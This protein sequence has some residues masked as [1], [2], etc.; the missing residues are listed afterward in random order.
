MLRQ[1]W[2]FVRGMRDYLRDPLDMQE[3]RAEIVDDW[4]RRGER[5]VEK[6][7]ATVWPFPDSPYAQL[8]NSAGFK[9]G[10]VEG[11]IAS[12]G[13]DATLEL[14]RDE[15][16]YVAYEEYQ[17]K[18]AAVRGSST[19][20]F[21][22]DDFINP[23]TRA[24]FMGSSSGTRSSGVQVPISFSAFKKG[25]TQWYFHRVHWFPEGTPN[26]VWIP[27]LPANGIGAVLW[28]AGTG[29][30]PDAWF[31]QIEPP[32]QI[33]FRKRVANALVPFAA[34]TTGVRIP[35]PVFAPPTDPGRVLDWCLKAL[36][37]RGR[38]MVLG[39]A[40]SLTRLALAAIERGVSL[41]GVTFIMSG[42]PVTSAKA[43]VI[44]ES[45][46]ALCNFYGFTQGGIVATN[47]PYCNDEELHV[48]EQDLAVIQRRRKRSDGSDVDAFLYTG[49]SAVMGVV[50]INLESDDFGE[51]RH[52]E[53]PCSCEFGKLGFRTRIANVRGMSKV[54]A[55][56]VTVPGE[57][58]ERIVESTL[59]KR[60]GGGPG[61]YQ[62]SESGGSQ[63]KLV[64]RVD[65]RL[66][67]ID[68]SEVLEC[69]RAELRS[70][71]YGLLA[72][73]VWLGADALEVAREP[74]APAR[75]GK[76]LPFETLPP[77]P[78][79]SAEHKNATK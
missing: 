74:A 75:S 66:G 12:R 52:D 14:L 62:F 76:V 67:G 70:T 63:T 73:R 71:E 11:L 1:G 49:L 29:D 3:A 36:S 53:T 43:Q 23:H 78:A 40:S 9:S 65:P 8:L 21:T 26:A 27:V 35:S 31:S 57:L 37:A 77:D 50:L 24:D 45:G 34:R 30:A 38:A 60:F 13:L 61:D 55:G 56:G 22:P 51:L 17:G 20:D 6:L 16:V 41:E 64:L 25:Q 48:L 2:E 19:F 46:A 54:V 18:E 59:P 15:G 72:D 79:V 28:V 5:F 32:R 47:C 58:L 33:P 68:E 44:R 10:D 4:R 39:Y 7:E 42:E 69:V